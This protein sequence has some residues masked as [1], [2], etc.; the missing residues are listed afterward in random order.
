MDYRLLRSNHARSESCPMGI[1]LIYKSRTLFESAGCGRHFA[2]ITSDL[3]CYSER[4][5][6]IPSQ[7]ALA[8]LRDAS[9]AVRSARYVEQR[10]ASCLNELGVIDH[11]DAT[12]LGHF[13]L[14]WDRLPTPL[15]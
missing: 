9:T 8:A 12:A 15:S 4:S 3:D 1:S 11:G 6:G 7:H 2:R 13:A 10:R 5:R 14:R